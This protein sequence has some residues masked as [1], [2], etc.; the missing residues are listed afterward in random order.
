MI[1]ILEEELVA[2]KHWITSED[3]LNML[4]I[5]ESTPG[6]IAVNTATS[7][8]FR[9]RGILGAIIATI[10]VVLP[11]FIIIT[12]LSFVIEFVAE[13]TWYKAAFTG[14]QACVTILII[15]AFIKVVSQLARDWF[16]V[17]A[18]LAAFAVATFTEFNAIYLILIGGVL[19][20]CYSL[21]VEAVKNKKQQKA[22]VDGN[23]DADD[24]SSESNEQLVNQQPDVTETTITGGG[25]QIGRE[26][27]GET[28]EHAETQEGEQNGGEK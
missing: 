6:V 28:S 13:N 14:I 3:M 22:V 16:N 19:G 7:V 15:N 1:A 18:V 12:G 26:A 21:I 27:N 9:L 24:G 4:V 8:G 2:K 23:A 10:G 5:A 20:L 11:S 17:V 25:A